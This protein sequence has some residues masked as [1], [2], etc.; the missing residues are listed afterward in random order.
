MRY[1]LKSQ[2]KYGRPVIRITVGESSR[3]AAKHPG[4]GVPLSR[5]PNQLQH[6]LREGSSATFGDL[7]AKL[8][9]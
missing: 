2:R 8:S 4:P 3:I 6:Q 9:L 5:L 7:I 1:T